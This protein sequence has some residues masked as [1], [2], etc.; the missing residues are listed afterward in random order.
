MPGTGTIDFIGAA[1]GNFA[2]PDLNGAIFSDLVGIGRLQLG[3]VRSKIIK[4]GN[5][6]TL[7]N[8]T[9]KTGGGTATGFVRLAPG[10]NGISY[11]FDVSLDQVDLSQV[12]VPNVKLGKIPRGRL[13]L[14]GRTRDL[15][16]LQSRIL[17]GLS[18]P[19]SW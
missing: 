11:D 5:E 4:Q 17:Q 6:Y 14:S 2:D 10:S 12:S 19:A 15:P 13:K 18:A 16:A 9:G 7:R 3:P 8:F 1:T